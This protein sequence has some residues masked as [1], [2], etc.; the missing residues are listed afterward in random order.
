MEER[1]Y[2]F[3][4]ADET[5]FS[6]ADEVVA[7]IQ[8]GIF[9]AGGRYRYTHARNATSIVMKWGDKLYGRFD[10]AFRERAT[11]SDQTDYESAAWTY[12]VVRSAVYAQSV[13]FSI[14]PNPYQVGGVRI[15]RDTL[16]NIEQSAGAITY[17]HGV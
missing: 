10:V 8:H 5:Q 1:I 9:T 16:N 6:S 2:V 3:G 17:F 11:L 13:D 14:V 7:Y 12:V 4:N 15:E